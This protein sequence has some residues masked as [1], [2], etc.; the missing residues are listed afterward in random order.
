MLLYAAM[1][2]AGFAQQTLTLDTISPDPISPFLYSDPNRQAFY[3]YQ[4]VGVIEYDYTENTQSGQKTG[5]G[6]IIVLPPPDQYSALS[7]D[8]VTYSP[9]ANAQVFFDHDS[10]IQ[11]T[12]T[13]NRADRPDCTRSSTPAIC[14]LGK[15]GIETNPNHQGY[16]EAY[17][18]VILTVQIVQQA[19][20]QLRV[21][22]RINTDPANNTGILGIDHIEVVQVDQDHDNNQHLVAGKTT[23]VRVFLRSQGDSAKDITTGISGSLTATGLTGSALRYANNANVMAPASPPDRNNPRDSMNFLLPAA[24][25]VPTRSPAGPLKLPLTLVAKVSLNN[26]PEQQVTQSAD[27]EQPPTWPATFRVRYVEVCAPDAQGNRQCGNAPPDDI[28]TDLM[29]RIYPVSDGGLDYGWQFGPQLEWPK[30]L[31]YTPYTGNDPT[32]T[33][34]AAASAQEKAAIRQQINVTKILIVYY[35]LLEHVTDQLFAWFP[36]SGHQGLTDFPDLSLSGLNTLPPTSFGHIWWNIGCAPAICVENPKYFRSVVAEGL[37]F[38]LGLSFDNGDQGPGGFDPR[39]GLVI[40]AGTAD[41]TD[42]GAWLRA[43][44]YQKLYQA[45]VLPPVPPGPVAEARPGPRASSAPADYLIISGTVGRTGPS[46]LD[47]GIRVTSAVAGDPSDPNGTHCLHFDGAGPDFCF[48]PMS[49]GTAFDSEFVVKAPVPAGTTSV[50]LVENGGAV[51]TTMT[52]AAGQPTLQIVT[53]QAGDS[54]EGTRTLQWSATDPGGN[55]LTYTVLYSP[56]NGASWIPLTIALQDTQYTVDGAQIAGGSQVLLRVLAS[57]GLLTTAATVGPVTVIQNAKPATDVTSLNFGNAAVGDFSESQVTVSNTGTGPASFN[58]QLPAGAFSVVSPGTASIVVRA[59]L[60]RAITVRFAPG[61]SGSQQATLVLSRTDSTQPDIKIAL[62]GIG[63]DNPVPNISVPLTFDFGTA[64]TAQPVSATVTIT[65]GGSAPLLVTSLSAAPSQYTVTA[66]AV[67]ASSPLSID[68]KTSSD[69]TVKFAPVSAVTV[70]GTLTI[71]SNDPSRATVTVKLTGTGVGAPVTSTCLTPPAGLVGWWSGD[72]S[73][74]DLAGGNNGTVQGGTT[75]A[76]GEVGRAF[77]F[78]GSTGYV[79]IGNPGNL[80]LPSAITIDAWVNPRSLKTGGLAA[81]VTKWAQ[82]FTDT[83]NSDSYG[84]WLIS[85]NGTIS[86]FSAIHQPGGKEPGPQGGTIPLN[87]WTHVAMTFDSASGQYV[88]YVNGQ[89]V[90][91]LNSSGAIVA[92]NHNVFIGREDSGQPRPFDGLLDEVQIFG[93]ALTA[94]EIQA[95]FN[96]GSA[97]QCKTGTVA[98]PV[99]GISAPSLD[100]GNVPVGQTPSPTMTVTI[101]NKG[102]GTLIVSSLTP[103][104][105]PF[106]LVSPPAT[107]FNVPAAGM[108]ITVRFTPTTASAQKATLTIG[109]NDPSNANTPVSLTGTGVAPTG[110]VQ[111]TQLV[112]DDGTFETIAGFP[113]GTATAYFVNRLTPPS[114]PATLRSVEIVFFNQPDGLQK[115]AALNILS[116]A[117]PSGSINIDN[118]PL[119]ST[120][121]SVAATDQFNSFKVTPITIQSGDFVVGFSAAN[122]PN[123]YLMAVDTSSG[124]KQRSYIG[125]DGRSFTPLDFIPALAGNFG[126][127][128]TVDVGGSA[129]TGPKIGTS[130]PSLDFTS[131]PLGQ[132]KDITL[133]I[134]NDGGGTLSVSLLVPPNA[135]FSLVSPPTA[136]FNVPATGVPITVR[137]LPT[138]TGTQ[139]GTLTIVNNDSTGDP[140][141]A[142]LKIPLTGTGTSTGG[143]TGTGSLDTSNPLSTNLV[144]LFAMNEGAGTT[145]K[146]LVDGQ[147]ATLSGASPPAFNASDPSILFKGGAAL[148]S[149]LNAGTDPIFD[150]LPVSQMTIVARV[151]ANTVTAAGICEKDDGNSA[152]GIVFGSNGTGGGLQ[153]TVEMSD[154]NMRVQSVG[155]ITAGKWIQVAVTWDGS[156]GTGNAADAHLFANGVE[157]AKVVNNSGSGTLGYAGATNQPFRI[158]TAAFDFPGSFDGKMQYLAVYKGRILTPAEMKQLD[159]KLP[160]K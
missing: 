83:A 149:Y 92:T 128:A 17:L 16:K 121:S 117:N 58:L 123:F 69:V 132:P 143:G 84:L 52:A 151:F 42:D 56:D 145:D 71:G 39:T 3:L 119:A 24:W 160:V 5:H 61:V 2:P 88:L 114:Y 31:G 21:F 40:P 97:G 142:T 155:A 73:A 55:P 99:I 32:S 43:P 23:A 54:W 77:Q 29:Q 141:R 98:T 131:S 102:A 139:T 108:P 100:F 36:A 20:L 15:V 134:T 46:V 62:T 107:P 118:L 90:K 116:G 127:R 105:G 150:K 115:G 95:I 34:A 51:L 59:G 50:S 76:A 130:A 22:F 148:N 14:D 13:V 65:N 8:F 113:N 9:D 12:A 37:S 41:L 144:G 112:V 26:G 147:L 87:T 45:Q 67:S 68:P 25:T 19:R 125:T 63:F 70:P 109:S 47:P 93:R 136:P 146:N 38:N 7:T 78:D 157:L 57:N 80:Q 94:S 138:A 49:F 120:A 137:F 53:P 11:V 101:T 86:L 154:R 44:Q 33:E 89:V 106:T 96:A 133:T 159:A 28:A 4:G 122:P 18:D 82:D 66:P 60:S 10:S 79:S 1:V 103:P 6:K 30:S 72:G 152:D 110:G 135:P 158:G 85:N 153:L 126:I 104:S 129:V 124:S 81:I 74:A 35:H 27:F 75:F 64:N 48:T 91:S 111:T 156:K 140:A